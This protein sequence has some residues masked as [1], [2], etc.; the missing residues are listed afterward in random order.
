MSAAK[1]VQR[2]GFE[3]TK[4]LADLESSQLPNVVF[5]RDLMQREQNRDLIGWQDKEVIGKIESIAKSSHQIA[6]EFGPE[7]K[8]RAP[9]K[10]TR[11]EL[12]KYRRLWSADNREDRFVTDNMVNHNSSTIPRFHSKPLQELRNVPTTIQRLQVR[13]IDLHG[14]LALHLLSKAFLLFDVDDSGT[15]SEQELEQLLQDFDIVFTSEQFEVVW[16]HFKNSQ[17]KVSAK[18]FIEGLAKPLKGARN[19]MVRFA[20]KHLA[21]EVQ[22]RVILEHLLEAFNLEPKPGMHIRNKVA[23]EFITT[24]PGKRDLTAEISE[25]Q[26]QTFYRLLSPAVQDDDEFCAILEGSWHFKM[27][28]TI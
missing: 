23:E 11:E 6:A 7:K 4:G 19:E 10:L 22:G 9:K 18:E 27:P 5:G 21:K 3:T 14:P 20:F 13:L 25:E 8:L 17:D 12:E 1:F 26:F 24:F 15:L 28:E 2:P 16:D